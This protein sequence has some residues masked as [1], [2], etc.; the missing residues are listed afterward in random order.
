LASLRKLIRL[1]EICLKLIV[2][3]PYICLLRSWL[4]KSITIKMTYGHLG[5][6]TS[7]F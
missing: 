2:A 1:T 7:S 4:N 6:L 3:L 5:L